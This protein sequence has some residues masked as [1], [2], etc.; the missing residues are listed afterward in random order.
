M[1]SAMLR[2]ELMQG[3]GPTSNEFHNGTGNGNRGM[4]TSADPHPASAWARSG[5]ITLMHEGRAVLQDFNHAYIA[6]FTSLGMITA[7]HSRGVCSGML[8]A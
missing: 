3:L 8:L 6:G 1:S 7:L 4:D 2:Q 5:F